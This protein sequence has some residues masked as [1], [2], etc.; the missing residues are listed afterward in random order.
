MIL[1]E[2]LASTPAYQGHL[3]DGSSIQKH[4]AGSMYPFVFQI[5]EDTAGGLG[6][7]EVVDSLQ[8]V[9]ASFTW[10]ILVNDPETTRVLRMTAYRLALER[11]EELARLHREGMR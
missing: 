8:R 2:A 10:D 1:R 11:G 9:R 7:A 6:Y 5:R 3:S 4:S